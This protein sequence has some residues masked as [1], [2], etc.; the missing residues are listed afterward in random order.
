MISHLEQEVA[1]IG[2]S[3]RVDNIEDS[4]LGDDQA[5]TESLTLRPRFAISFDEPSVVTA[6]ILAFV[7]AVEITDDVRVSRFAED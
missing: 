4:F 5:M 7:I 3:G 2:R 6:R 1:A